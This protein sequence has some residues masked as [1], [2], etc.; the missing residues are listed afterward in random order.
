MNNLDQAKHTIRKNPILESQL[1]EDMLRLVTFIENNPQ[2]K[3]FPLAKIKKITNSEANEKCLHIAI[4][5]C[6][7]KIKLFE[8][9]YSYILEDN[10]ELELTKNEFKFY[11]INTNECLDK[12]GFFI[13]PVIKERLSMYFTTSLSII[14]S[15][16][17]WDID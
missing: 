4:Y 5:F 1:K 3:Y 15:L 11:L 8:P 13:C 14:S 9:R 6:G 12:D 7:E 10:C 16:D 17:D 2:V